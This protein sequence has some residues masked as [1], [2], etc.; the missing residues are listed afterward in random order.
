MAEEGGSSAE[1]VEAEMLR[2]MQ[3]EMSGASPAEPGQEPAPETGAAEGEAAAGGGDIDSLLE[4]EM[5]KA[6]QEETVTAAP[7]MAA[8]TSPSLSED[9]EGIDRL[10]DVEVE[11]TVELGDSLIP[12][13]DIMVWNSG[14][15]VELTPEEHD[16]VNVLLNGSVFARGEI[17]VVGDNFGVRITELMDQAESL[18]GH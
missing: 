4:Q 10:T 3:E 6:M 18:R 11:V 1:D 2:M 14:S 13:Q 8:F 9:Y 7:A 17:V 15:V 5:L 12:I 16:P